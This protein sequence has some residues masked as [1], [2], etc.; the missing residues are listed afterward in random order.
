MDA[1][2]H[3]DWVQGLGR[4]SD[5]PWRRQRQPVRRL[6]HVGEQ[7]R[8]QKTRPLESGA[9][10]LVGALQTVLQ[11]LGHV[12]DVDVAGSFEVGDRT[13]NGKR[14]VEGAHAQV[15]PRHRPAQEVGGF[16]ARSQ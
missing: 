14:A 16:V 13:R 15:P 11:R 1:W 4:V 5:H 10:S 9:G 2:R 6:L 12:L 3:Q 7:S 8:M